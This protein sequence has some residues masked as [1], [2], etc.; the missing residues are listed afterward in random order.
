VNSRPGQPG[1][2]SEFQASQH[3]IVS[4]CLKKKY[5]LL[6]GYKKVNINKYNNRKFIIDAVRVTYFRGDRGF[7]LKDA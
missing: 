4:P 7:Y 6:G 3:Y 2:Q 1:L 5:N